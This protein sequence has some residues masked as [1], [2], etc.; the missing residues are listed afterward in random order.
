MPPEGPEPPPLCPNNNNINCNNNVTIITNDNNNN[1]N[2][3]YL[4]P[5]NGGNDINS[6][7]ENS[8]FQRIAANFEWLKIKDEIIEKFNIENINILAS[9]NYNKTIIRIA[10]FGCATGPNTFLSVQNII[11]SIKQKYKTLNIP[12][13]T[14]HHDHEIT[15]RNWLEFQVFFNDLVKNDFNTLFSSLPK[16]HTKDYF[17]AA[18]PGSFR[19]QLFPE[20]SLH[21][22]YTSHSLH[23]LSEL[24]EELGDEASP[25]WNKGRIHYTGEGTPSGVVEAYKSQFGKEME[26][27]LEAR[28]EELV[29]GGMLFMI[30][31]GSPKDM[32]LSSTANATTFDFMASI[33][34]DL[35]Q[36]GMIEESEVDSFNMPLYN[37]ASPEDMKDLVERN[38]CFTIERLELSK[39]SSWLDNKEMEQV[40]EMI[41]V[42]MK[43]VRAVMEGNFIQHFNNNKALLLVDQLFTRLTKMHLDHSHLLQ[44]WCNQKV[45]LFVVL[46][47]IQYQS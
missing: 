17:A 43:H 38:G 36:E 27:F 37:S 16:D 24:P 33:L 6:Y 9:N 41:Q 25:A 14:H 26:M 23:W 29:V 12:N 8:S 46:K 4:S 22:A 1:N 30:F 15:T 2:V 13:P 28:A 10:D 5:M 21:F 20:A 42:W 7:Y 35:V 31:C 34:K 11:E 45:Q 19:G 47:R 39:P 18:V 3:T 44:L 40:E 32:P